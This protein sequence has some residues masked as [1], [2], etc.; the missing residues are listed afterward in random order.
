MSLEDFRSKIKEGYSTDKY[1]L[2][3]RAYDFAMQAHQG[4]KR[5]SGENYIIHPVAVAEILTT[6]SMDSEVIIAAL[7]HD[8]LE[9]TPITK[10]DILK[11]FG[12]EIESLVSGVTKLKML[13]YSNKE[14][15]QAENLRRM[16][17]AM[18]KDIRVII[19]KLADR[20]HNMRTLSYVSPEKQLS[21]ARETMDIYAPLAGR[22]GISSIKCELDDLSMMYLYPEHY[23]IITAQ[24]SDKVE[25]R[26]LIVDKVCEDIRA[27]LIIM[28][29]NGEVFGRQKHLYS[30]YKK[31]VNQ[32]K[33][34]HEIY[35]LIAVRVLV[36]T[37]KDCYAVLGEIHEKWKPLPGRF[38]DYIAMP[39]P[40][41]YQSLHTTVITNYGSP[42][43]IQIRTYEMHKIAE[44][45]I[46]AHWKYKEG[47]QTD[48][49]VEKKFA[50]LRSMLESQ[51]EFRDS[52]E[53]LDT[54]KTGLYTDEV[55]VFT[56]KGDVFNLPLD[57]TGIDF[58][59]AIHS[60]V[61]N[62]CVGVKIN[63]KIVPLNTKLHTGDIVEILTSNTSKGPSRDW[64]KIVKTSSAKAKIKQFFKK[65][66]REENI[67]R[68]RLMLERQA[69][70]N[71]YEIEELLK[72][73]NVEQIMNKY[74]LQTID[75]LYST[76][77]YG[78]ITTNQVIFKLIELYKKDATNINKLP[79][80]EEEIKPQKNTSG[81]IVKGFND[82]KIRFANCCNPVPGD[83]ITGFISRGRG[84][85]IHRKDCVNIKSLE[86]ARMIDAEWIKGAHQS[87]IASIR[88]DA[89]D[90][91]GLFADVSKTFYE[92][93]ISLKSA[94]ARVEKNHNAIITLSAEL[95][96]IKTLDKIISTLRRLDGVT[97]V[98]R[99]SGQ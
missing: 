55:F 4:Q 71:G 3:M 95:D 30:I 41:L 28:N 96:D 51:A 68:G 16:F 24:L 25:E 44:Y 85:T 64:L 18:A 15:E 57:S 26:Q 65:E 61:G 89:V 2:I 93:N 6:L 14:E 72:Q 38:K 98:R 11:E 12:E 86:K 92:N 53:F 69:K 56:P 84:V 83:G 37:V 27:K 5:K 29:L 87:F 58:A 52:K 9:D 32:N 22:L 70:R 20:L 23:K 67:K 90:R 97:N 39:K 54:L 77:G 66:M 47:A 81:V 62:K 31:M 82:F 10:A 19:I 78:G 74:N 59:Y 8:A 7:L 80:I 43:E 35:D 76:V 60:A 99:T 45:G 91:A 50:W 13:K 75:D 63:N 36:E 48:Q 46:A 49:D 1:D 34:L 21:I 94:N 42:I 40:N 73:E 33:E 17:I 79:V 88:I